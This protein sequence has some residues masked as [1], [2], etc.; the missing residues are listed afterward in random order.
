M[1]SAGTPIP[2]VTV[3]LSASSAHELTTNSSGDAS[4]TGLTYIFTNMFAFFVLDEGITPLR[5]LGIG[6][7]AIGAAIVGWS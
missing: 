2:G 3:Y 5:W 7:I 1:S 4:F 6:V